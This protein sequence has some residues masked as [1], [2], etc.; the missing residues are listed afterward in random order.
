[1]AVPVE[2]DNTQTRSSNMRFAWV[3]STTVLTKSQHAPNE[4]CHVI[5][6]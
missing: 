5:L 6:G 4:G 3:F 2:Q 1:M